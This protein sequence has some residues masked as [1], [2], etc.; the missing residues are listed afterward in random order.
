[1]D[2]PPRDTQG[3]TNTRFDLR[4]DPKPTRGKL[5]SASNLDN[6][7]RSNT[8]LPPLWREERGRNKFG[9]ATL[10]AAFYWSVH[11]P[12]RRGRNRYS[13]RSIRPTRYKASEEH[14]PGADRQ[15]PPGY[16][17]TLVI[18]HRS[19]LVSRSGLRF[20]VKRRA[21]F[22]R[23]RLSFVCLFSFFQLPLIERRFVALQLRVFFF[24]FLRRSNRRRRRRR[25]IVLEYI[26]I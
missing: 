16:E 3:Y 24:F 2:H 7:K 12:R 10:R 18:L 17:C 21:L 5:T 4:I 26:I 13:R 11:E 1:M 15:S 8:G 23:V 25:R 20:F 19:T 6:R 9:R 22:A 14:Q